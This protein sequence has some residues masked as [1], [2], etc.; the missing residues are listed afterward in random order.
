MENL[1]ELKSVGCLLDMEKGIVYPQFKDGEPDFSLPLHLREEEMSSDWY[2][3][4]SLEDGL[5][6]TKSLSLVD[7][8]DG[9]KGWIMSNDYLDVLKNQINKNG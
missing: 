5:H 1:I 6:V 4:L 9:N 7:K 2:E 8:Y 3:E